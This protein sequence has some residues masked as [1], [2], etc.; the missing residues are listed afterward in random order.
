M[1]AT[2]LRISST[3]RS[4]RPVNH[5]IR[6]AMR[7]ITMGTHRSNDE[8]STSTLSATSSRF[9]PT[10]MVMVPTDSVR[11]GRARTRN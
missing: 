4:T 3:G 2:S 1:V 7:P 9:L 10:T 6:I 5:H 11:T 8:R